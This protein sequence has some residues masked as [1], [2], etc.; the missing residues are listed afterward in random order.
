FAFGG[1]DFVIILDLPSNV[2]MAAVALA[3]NASGAVETRITVL[4][5]PGEI[6]QATKRQGKFRPPAGKREDAIGNRRAGVSGARASVSRRTSRAPD[7]A[8]ASRIFTT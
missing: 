2:D 3:A 1:D 6:D 4:L 7:R 5:L 8:A